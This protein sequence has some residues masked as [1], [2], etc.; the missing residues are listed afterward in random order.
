M[1]VFFCVVFATC[2]RVCVLY[3]I[4][5]VCLCFCASTPSTRLLL[6]VWLLLD[7]IDAIEGDVASSKAPRSTKDAASPRR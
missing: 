3:A 6:C 1:C 7:A 5:A 4:D 2:T